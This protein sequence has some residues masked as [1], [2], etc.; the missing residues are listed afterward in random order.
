MYAPAEIANLELAVN[1]EEQVLGL[2]ISVDDML[3]V[4]V[5]K[6]VRHLRDVLWASD[7]A[8][9]RGSIR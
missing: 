5:G 6:S 8:G 1:A 7:S 9:Q 4:E 2:D 3:A